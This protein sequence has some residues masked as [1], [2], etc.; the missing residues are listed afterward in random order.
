MTNDSCDVRTSFDLAFCDA[1]ET[2]LL[3]DH[4][5]KAVDLGDNREFK[6]NS[7]GRRRQRWQNNK[8][9]YTRQ[10]A[11]VNK[12]NKADIHAVLLS[13]ET[14]IAP[15]PRRLQNVVNISRINVDLFV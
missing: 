6:Q 2:A 1:G 9:N 12:W 5:N 4:V 8:T 15:F 14:S 7:R 10:K 3:K 11:H 13:F